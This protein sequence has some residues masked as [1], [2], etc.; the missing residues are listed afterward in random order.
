MEGFGITVLEA[1]IRGLPVVAADLEG[2]KDSVEEDKNGWLVPPGDAQGFVETIVRRLADPEALR[3]LGEEAKRYVDL[4]FSW[5]TIVRRYSK[6]LTGLAGK[7]AAN[8]T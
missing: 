3:I 1:G 5:Q 2:L 6:L 7:A 8:N 4:N